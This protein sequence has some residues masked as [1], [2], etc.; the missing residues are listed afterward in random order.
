[1]SADM[2]RELRPSGVAVVSLW[3]GTVKTELSVKLINNGKLSAITGISQVF[4]FFFLSYGNKLSM[5]L[6]NNG[7]LGAIIDLLRILFLL[8]F[9]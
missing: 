7:K 1:M 6:V 8:L 2:A 4:L 5:A 9:L 3:P